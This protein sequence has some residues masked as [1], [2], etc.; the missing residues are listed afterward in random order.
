MYSLSGITIAEGVAAGVARVIVSRA[1]GVTLFENDPKPT[2]LDPA[3]ELNRYLKASAS[4]AENCATRS[5][6]QRPTR[7]AISSGRCRRF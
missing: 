6:G 4:F 2:T 7:C 3:Y 5:R 1:E